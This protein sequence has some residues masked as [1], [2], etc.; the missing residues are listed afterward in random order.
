MRLCDAFTLIGIQPYDKVEVHYQP[1][2][3]TALT[4]F[5]ASMSLEELGNQLEGDEQMTEDEIDMLIELE[6]EDSRSCQFERIFPVASNMTYYAQFFE[7]K[8]YQNALV[9]AYLNTSQEK[10]AQLLSSHKRIYFDKV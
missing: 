7:S 1:D 8:H 10:K 5:A 6:E 2:S 4:P 9:M 3:L